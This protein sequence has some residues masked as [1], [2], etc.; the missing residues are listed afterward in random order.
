MLDRRRLLALAA[1]SGLVPRIAAAQNGFPSRPIRMIVPVGVGGVTDVVG[2]IVADGMTAAL[3]QSV[4]VENVAGAGSTVGAAAFERTAPDG[5][6]IFMATN[7]HAVMQRMYPNFPQDPVADFVPLAL[8]GRQPFI[9]A[10]HPGVPARDVP[11]LLAW[12]RQKGDAADYGATNPGAT[13]HLAGELLKQLAALSFTVVPYRTA[14]N[15]VTDLVA[16]RVQFTIDSPT[17]LIPLIRE[18]KLRGLAVSSTEPSELAPGLP[19]LAGAG[20]AGYDMTAWQVLYARPGTPDGVLAVLRD[21]AAR[22]LRDP[23]LRAR[24][25]QVGVETW[26]DS[27]PAAADRHVRAEVERWSPIVARINPGR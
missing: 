19:S 2:R 1:G 18:G 15:A 12:L 20:V 4:L 25:L 9:L 6:T 14:A 10:A 8:V 26:P 23:G 7:N 13:N 3:G 5:Y 21:A 22:S 16:G 17:M 11:E 24:L 27:S